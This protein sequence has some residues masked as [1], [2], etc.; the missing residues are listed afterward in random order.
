MENTASKVIE[1]PN[2][3]KNYGFGK[4]TKNQEAQVK[5]KP[6][7]LVIDDETETTEEVSEL[8]SCSGFQ[9]ETAN[10]PRRALEIFSSDPTISIILTDIKMPGIDGLLL[11]KMM[12]DEVEASRDFEMIIMSGYAGTEETIE[13][14]R[15][16]AIDFISKP[17]SPDYILHSVGRASEVLGL[18]INKSDLYNQLEIEVDIRTHQVKS[19]TD[20]LL[21]AN[22][23]LERQNLELTAANRVKSEFLSLISN[24]FRTP[25]ASVTSFSDL[26]SILKKFKGQ[27]YSK[28]VHKA[29]H[30]LLWMIDT[31]LDLIDIESGNLTLIKNDLD[32]KLIMRRL[33]DDLEPRAAEKAVG[34]HLHLESD[35]PKLSGDIKRITQAFKY[36]LDNAIKFSNTGTEVLV[37]IGH[38]SN[39]IT[40]SV[41]DQGIGFSEEDIRMV[42]DAF[43]QADGSYSKNTYDLGLG[44]KLS[45]KFIELHGGVL[46]IESCAGYG[47]TIQMRIPKFQED[48]DLV[49]IMRYLIDTLEPIAAKKSVYILLFLESDIP[50]VT[51]D[52]KLITRAFKYVLENAVKLSITDT[53]ILVNIGHNNKEI[54][55]SVADQG[56]GFSEEDIRTADDGSYGTDGSFPLNTYAFD[57][58]LE[59]SQ[60]F[61]EMHGGV[62]NIETCAGDGTTVQIRFPIFGV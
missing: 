19:L 11:M 32:L 1:I 14:L 43:Y 55:I 61:I 15:L 18:R 45:Q 27:K 23:N 38:N 51:G 39:E 31:I 34:I 42:G 35:I 28:I 46:N 30:K 47:T 54:I 25:L 41:T 53:E 49:E 48:V 40:I 7:V 29:G 26:L 37:D 62:L 33:I 57:Q 9:C 16:G 3:N 58:E 36:V 24:E 2:S 60:K 44:L 12:R 8:I 22:K 10:D 56:I 50:K 59:L 13:A 20:D 6:K 5:Y 4:K 21:V 52:I 17:L